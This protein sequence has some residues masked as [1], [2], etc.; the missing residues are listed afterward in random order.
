MEIETLLIFSLLVV[1]FLC[2]IILLI[3]QMPKKGFYNILKITILGNIFIIPFFFNNFENIRNSIFCY[4]YGLCYFT[5]FIIYL[6]IYFYDRI[7][8]LRNW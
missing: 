8:I 1:E 5:Y 4:F 6:H 2:L 7:H 3:I